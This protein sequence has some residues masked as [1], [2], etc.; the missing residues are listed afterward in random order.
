MTMLEAWTATPHGGKLSRPEGPIVEKWMGD[1]PGMLP[2][3]DR[4]LVKNGDNLPSSD[5]MAGDWN[6]D[7]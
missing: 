3:F 1:K 6:A 2:S 7:T 5:L 4:W